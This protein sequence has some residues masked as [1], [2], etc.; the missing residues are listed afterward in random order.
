MVQLPNEIIN[1][2]FSYLQSNTNQI[3][4]EATP[5]YYRVWAGYDAYKWGIKKPTYMREWN[6]PEIIQ[7]NT[8]IMKRLFITT[9]I[10]RIHIFINN[11]EYINY[12]TKGSENKFDRNRILLQRG[13]L[14]DYIKMGRHKKKHRKR[15]GTK[16]MFEK[17]KKLYNLRKTLLISN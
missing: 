2:I 6:L 17:S 3:I 16:E 9:C 13:I 7:N 14:M 12:H 11:I 8:K 4:K 15:S 10:Q 5:K 1:K